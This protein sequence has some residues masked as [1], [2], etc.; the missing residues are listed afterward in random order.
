MRSPSVDPHDAAMS[1]ATTTVHEM[2]R[3]RPN[4]PESRSLAIGLTFVGETSTRLRSAQL[5]RVACDQGASEP[6]RAESGDSEPGHEDDR[7]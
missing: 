3:L 1:A 2:S 7:G 5:P 4:T 6:I